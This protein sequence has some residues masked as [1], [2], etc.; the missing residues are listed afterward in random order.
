M[1]RNRVVARYGAVNG[2]VEASASQGSS[3][4]TYTENYE[5]EKKAKPML[6]AGSDSLSVGFRPTCHFGKVSCGNGRRNRSERMHH[7]IGVPFLRNDAGVK[8]THTHE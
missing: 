2:D 3:V 1:D 5:K 8:S 7:T 4:R 6:Q